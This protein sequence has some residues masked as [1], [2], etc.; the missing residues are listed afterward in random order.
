M[1]VQGCVL[2]AT[3]SCGYFG[4]VSLFAQQPQLSYVAIVQLRNKPP[5]SSLAASLL[6]ILMPKTA[7]NK[8]LCT[9]LT[10][11]GFSACAINENEL[12]LRNAPAFAKIASFPSLAA[13]VITAV[14]N[15][16]A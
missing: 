9:N 3:C 12:L 14:W 8:C 5:C 16:Y 4:S 1:Y 15:G 7:F 13:S 2:D 10:C 6:H 11:F